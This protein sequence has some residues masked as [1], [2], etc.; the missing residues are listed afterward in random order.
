MA[1]AQAM[2]TAVLAALILR[3]FL[4]APPQ[5]RD[6]VAAAGWLT[7]AVVLLAAVPLADTTGKAIF[8][9]GAAVSAAIAGWW[10]RGAR[11]DGEGGDGGEFVPPRPPPDWEEF[12]RTREE[13]ARASRRTPC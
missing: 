6:V 8:S 7:A 4:G 9:A 11:H 12:E 1:V 10:L 3:A 2:S 13:W 5:E